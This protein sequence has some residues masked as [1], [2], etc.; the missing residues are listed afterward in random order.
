MGMPPAI[1]PPSIAGQRMPGIMRRSGTATG[2]FINPTTA[3]ANK[4][5]PSAALRSNIQRGMS[6]AGQEASKLVKPPTPYERI[7]SQAAA[8]APGMAGTVGRLAGRLAGGPVGALLGSTVPANSGENEFARQA[9]YA[10]KTTP[11]SMDVSKQPAPTVSTSAAAEK[12]GISQ[13]A[14]PSVAPA[15]GTAKP[16]PAPTPTPAA[17]TPTAN[18]SGYYKGGSQGDYTVKSGETLSGIAKKTGQSVSDLASMNK[19]ADVNK[20]SSGTKLMTKVPTPPSRPA[21]TAST[22]ASTPA[23]PVD[24][25][26][27]NPPTT[28]GNPTPVGGGAITQDAQKK[29][30]TTQDAGTSSAPAPMAESVVTVG[31]NK[32]RIV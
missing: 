23:A 14:K 2:S 7:A 3:T 6:A 18:K 22:P 20:I 30:K 19:I 12:V 25:S 31:V 1:T 10:P 21:D 4:P 8:K 9:K 16:A 17:P 29:Q 24:R 26:S 11:G 27:S 32:Y 15:A 28:S 13:T 5:N